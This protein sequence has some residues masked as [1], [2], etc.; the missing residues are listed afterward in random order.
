M[1][2]ETVVSALLTMAVHYYLSQPPNRDKKLP[3]PPKPIGARVIYVTPKE[4][5]DE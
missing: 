3:A 1:L 5:I 2:L 4:R